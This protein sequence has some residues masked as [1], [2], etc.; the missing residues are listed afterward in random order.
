MALSL[1]TATPGFGLDLPPWV[2]LA[3]SP[4]QFPRLTLTWRDLWASGGLSPGG[5]S[6]PGTQAERACPSV[7]LS[8][9]LA[10]SVSYAS[11]CPSV[12]F[13]LS[14]SL[15]HYRCTNVSPEPCDGS[16]IARV[17]SLPTF[18]DAPTVDVPTGG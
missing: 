4:R 7:C 13:S 2:R 12:S 5:W 3:Q 15:P 11:L 16:V 1:A 14:C 17:P 18:P 9:S 6:G 8:V 10:L